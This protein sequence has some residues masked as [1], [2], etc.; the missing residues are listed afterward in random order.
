MY[1]YLSVCKGTLMD[2]YCGK[3]PLKKPSFTK[4][5]THRRLQKKDDKKLI[6]MSNEAHTF[7]TQNM[8]DTNP[9]YNL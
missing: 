3:D 1:A 5:L 9:Q 4:V 8:S 2:P 6:E 7:I